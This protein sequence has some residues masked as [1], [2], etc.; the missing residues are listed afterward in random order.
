M[1]LS[2]AVRLG[3]MTGGQIKWDLI[4]Q[5]GNTCAIGA[6]MVAMG[7][8]PSAMAHESLWRHFPC[9]NSNLVFGERLQYVIVDLNNHEGWSRER[10]ADW[11]ETSG[12][13][14]ESVEAPDPFPVKV[15]A[16][17]GSTCSC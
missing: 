17:I 3:A 7:I 5:H 14:M 2:E 6:A 10:I 13:D 11:L 12:N 1:R 4:D 8:K 15:A 16:E 9:L